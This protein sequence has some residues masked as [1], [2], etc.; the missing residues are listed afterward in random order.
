MGHMSL[1]SLALKIANPNF[2]SQKGE[3][4]YFEDRLCR[5]YYNRSIFYEIPDTR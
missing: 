4:E 3:E 1:E 5:G 2:P